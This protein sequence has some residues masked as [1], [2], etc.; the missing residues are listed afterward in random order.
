MSCF[1]SYTALNLAYRQSAVI[2][3][4]RLQALVNVGFMYE[5]LGRIFTVF[6]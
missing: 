3:T 6:Q 4:E 5:L 1:F 2:Y